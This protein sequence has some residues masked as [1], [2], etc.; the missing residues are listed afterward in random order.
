[1]NEG[2]VTRMLALLATRALLPNA[3]GLECSATPEEVCDMCLR[4]L[5]GRMGFRSG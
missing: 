1:M 4:V 3:R 2:S 5:Y